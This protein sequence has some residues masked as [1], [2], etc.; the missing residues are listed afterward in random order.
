MFARHA[1]L[2]RE[3]S[4]R[5]VKITNT[6]KTA[7][8]DL[9]VSFFQA[10]FMDSAT[11]CARI[12]ELPAGQSVEV[13]LLATFNEQVFTTNGVT[14]LTG[15][16]VTSYSLKGRAAEQRESVSYDLHD[17]TAISWDDDR[18]VGAFIT[19]ADS[20]LQNYVSFVRTSLQGR[21]LE[22]VQRPCAARH[23]AVRVLGGDGNDLPGRPGSPF[24]KAQG[25]TLVVDS[26][27]LPRDT[28]KRSTGDCDD[29]TVLYCSL[30]EAAGSETGFI[31]VPGHIYPVVNTGYESRRFRELN[32]DRSLTL[33][34]DGTLWLPVEITLLGKGDF[35]EAWRTG[36]ELWKSYE[37]DPAKRGFYRTREAQVVYRPVGLRESDLGLQYGSRDALLKVFR[38]DLTR[39]AEVVTEDYLAA[40]RKSNGKEDYNRLGMAYVQFARYDDAEQAFNKAAQLDKSYLTPRVNLANI[41]YL[42]G[43]LNQALKSYQS[44]LDALQQRGRQGTPIAQ[45]VLLNISKTYYELQKYP[46]A[47]NFFAQAEKLNPAGAEEFAYLGG[48]GG[49]R[50][51]DVG[52]SAERLLFAQED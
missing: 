42:R 46:D 38:R 19:P 36:C 14:P 32:P 48:G 27:K 40:A 7:V 17:K 39:L 8:T 16:L 43:N 26:V 31:T 2:L 51:A 1:E 23:A 29:L 50:A 35:L 52:S 30:L 4:H 9:Q 10:G 28:L 34:I 20:A 12:P 6:E 24:T 18:K 5:H 49:A 47:K 45:T 13:Q 37:K 15:E 11:S 22:H 33:D 3:E 44:V 25:D 21:C 41:A